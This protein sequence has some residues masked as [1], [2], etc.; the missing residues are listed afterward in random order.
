CPARRWSVCA[1]RSARPSGQRS[2]GSSAAIGT[3][4]R[5]RLARLQR[6]ESP[7]RM[8]N[9]RPPDGPALATLLTLAAGA[10]VAVV[11]L[12]GGHPYLTG[13]SLTLGLGVIALGG[14]I[15]AFRRRLGPIALLWGIVAWVF[16]LALPVCAESLGRRLVPGE[17]TGLHD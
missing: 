2:P 8:A 7:A 12:S 14:T 15:Q 10:A 4:R 1:P 6:D 17:G 3:P 9:S 11:L 16:P 5:T 13:L